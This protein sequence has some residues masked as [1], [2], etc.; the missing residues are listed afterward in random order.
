VAA[1]PPYFVMPL[2]DSSL[3]ADRRVDPTLGD[4]YLR[5]VLDIIS[6]LEEIHSM[7][8]YH[9]DLK[10]A[11]V[12]RFTDDSGTSP[13]PYYAIGDFGLMSYHNT[14]LSTLTQTGMAMSSDFYTA[15]EITQDLKNASVQSDVYSLGCIIHDF[16]QQEPR[17]PCAEI[18]DPGPY[19]ALLS[20]CTRRDP[21][22]RFK[23]V[24]AVR[25]ALLAM[26]AVALPAGTQEA[27]LAALLE[28]SRSLTRDEW[29]QISDF[30]ESH[31]ES[32][33][34][35]SILA[36]LTL[37]RITELCQTHPQIAR[38]LAL[39][40]AAWV[41]DQWFIFSDCDG[42]A[43]RVEYFLCLS[44]LNITAECLMSLLYMGTSHNRWYVEKKFFSLALPHMD[45]GL[46]KRLAVEFRADAERVCSAIRHLE[47]SIGVERSSFHP[48]LVGTLREICK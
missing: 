15:P 41:R 18:H 2:A 3:A 44:D 22:R 34:G 27:E 17:V 39:N 47:H 7:G 33:E 35:K 20:I 28:T 24:V 1:A 10:P 13:Q 40:F 45:S 31:H 46:A 21:S 37:Q 8:I 36:R 25:D 23:S 16:V 9:R 43:S 38:P 48:L 30:V 4:E 6:G 42:V 29:Q 12:L 5:A 14:Q 26:G 32:S 11:N 19:G